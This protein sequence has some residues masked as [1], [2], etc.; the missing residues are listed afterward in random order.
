MASTYMP[1]V[2]V[3][4][5]FNAGV[6]TDPASRTWTDVSTYVELQY[7]M[8]IGHGR[9]SEFDLVDANSLS[10]VF[11][12]T[13]GR[14]TPGLS[15]GAYYPNVLIGRPI[16]VTATPVG[17]AASTRFLGF[18][19][20]W[21]I[22]WDGAETAATTRVAAASRMSRLGAGVELK[23]IVEEEILADSPTVYYTMGDVAGST[24]AADSIGGQ[25]LARA[26]SGAAV[27]FGD[28]AGSLY[29]SLTAAT[30]TGGGRT[31]RVA[32]STAFQCIEFFIS[33]SGSA[34]VSLNNGGFVPPF[35]LECTG[36]SVQA[37]GLSLGYVMDTTDGVHHVA[38]TWVGSTTKLYVD[39]VEVASASPGTQLASSAITVGSNS[40]SGVVSHVALFA[41]APIA[42]RILSHANAGRAGGA[43][44]ASDLRFVK[45]ADFAGS[46]AEAGAYTGSAT[47]AWID[48]TGI[49]A[50]DA[51]RATEA[52]EGGL[53]FDTRAGITTLQNRSSRYT[54]A[55]EFTLD[56]DLQQVEADLNQKLDRT[57]LANEANI[58]NA[59]GNGRAVDTASQEAYG[60][61]R[62]DFT[63]YDTD[64]DAGN[65]A[66][67]WIVGNYATP[68]TRL[69]QI[70]ID[71]LPFAVATQD[72]IFAADVNTRF[73]VSNQP[74][75]MPSATGDY[76]I[77][78]YAESIG[79]ESYFITF[80]VS[81]AAMYCGTGGG[82]AGGVWVL[83]DT[84]R[85]VLGTTTKVAW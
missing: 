83:D 13:D 21:D 72:D 63:I 44:D 70:S 34:Y 25:P 78:G 32:N 39:G 23:S 65:A 2:K 53:M 15:S 57:K 29:D 55:S 67:Q 81:D 17:G 19:D 20:E 31:M 85:S 64:D 76:F 16:R 71:L 66:A 61:A 27:V 62:K 54:A 38:A 10:L 11:D 14:F 60:V 73:G 40:S 26:G 68:V 35:D 84:T 37:F 12:N 74:A 51:M 4:I 45:Y 79:L 59:A 7:G 8:T 82:V 47:M 1:D 48:T 43:G 75:Q 50:M 6:N 69:P 30:F 41:S 42:G 33:G 52:T 18:V 22:S 77:E 46:I 9:G 5:A 3:E 36:G 28:A 49:T 80:N 24:T 58:T 56:M